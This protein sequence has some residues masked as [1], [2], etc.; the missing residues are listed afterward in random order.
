MSFN[1]YN[2]E[3]RSG[4]FVYFTTEF[5][6]DKITSITLTNNDLTR[7]TTYTNVDGDFS[8]YGGFNL[9]KSYQS[10]EK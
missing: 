7:K 1:N 5:Q 2:W 9:D 10:G 3:T 6:E 8:V 4:I